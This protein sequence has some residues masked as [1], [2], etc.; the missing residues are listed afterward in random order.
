MKKAYFFAAVSIIFWSS[1]AAISK[2]MLNDFSSYVILTFSS[3][4]AFLALLAVNFFKG[5]LKQLKNYKV[6]DYIITTLI[7]LPGTFLYYVF[8]YLGTDRMEASKAFIINY[9]WPIMSV[10]FACIILKEKVT[11][12]KCIAFA[13]SFLGVFTVASDNLLNFK[14]TSFIGVFFLILAAVC[15]GLFTVL[16]KKWDYDYLISMMISFFVTIIFSLAIV[17]SLRQELYANAIQ[18]LGFAYNGIFIMAIATVTWALALK[19]G[20]TAKI[21][22]LAYITPFLSLVWTFLILQEPIKPLSLLGLIIIVIGI[23]I[24]LKDNKK[25]VV[26]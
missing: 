5:N 23:F 6:K 16:N 14:S 9:L 26:N 15:Y 3:F 17:L 13:L 25:A 19:L 1:L 2:L 18:I 21:S 11:L 20:G 8:L 7:C 4:F 12:R 24:Q 22:N 10:V